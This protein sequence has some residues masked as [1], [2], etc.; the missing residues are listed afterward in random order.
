MAFLT[1]LAV[2]DLE[3]LLNDALCLL[4]PQALHA[5]HRAD[6]RILA[7][8]RVSELDGVGTGLVADQAADCASLVW[9]SVGFGRSCKRLGWCVVQRKER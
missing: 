4:V 7:S 2:D 3:S 8:L 5:V 1:T 6:E 9:M